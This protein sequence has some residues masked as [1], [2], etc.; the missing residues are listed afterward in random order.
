MFY[1]NEKGERVYTMKV[2][3]LYLFQGLKMARS[4]TTIKRCD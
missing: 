2:F 4:S 3:I 1:L